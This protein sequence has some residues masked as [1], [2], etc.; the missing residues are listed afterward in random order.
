MNKKYRILFIASGFPPYEFSENIING[1]L[2]LALLK[3]GHSVNVISKIDEGPIYN[4]IWQD[5][6]LPLK[7]STHIVTYPKINKLRRVFEIGK[8]VVTFKYPLEGIRWAE[9]AYRKSLEYI[10]AGQVDVI[11]TRSPSD[12]AHLVG[13]RLKKEYKIRWIANWN[14]PSTG[15][16]PE[17]YKDNL[18]LWKKVSFRKFTQEALSTADVNTFP[19]QLLSEHFK[20]CFHINERKIKIIPHIM[21]PDF[22]S[23]IVD[24]SSAPLHICHS[25]NLS[26][27]RDPENLFMAIKKFILVKKRKIYFEVLGVATPYALSLIKKH[28]LDKFVKF[29]EPLPYY[30]ALKKMTQYDVLMILE[31]KME[32]SIFL[33]SKITDYAQLNK[34]ILSL[35]PSISEVGNVLQRYGG[36]IIANTVS[37]DDIYEKICLLDDLKAENRLNELIKNSELKEYLGINRILNLYDNLFS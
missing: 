23:V 27:E 15:I 30:A 35:S 8:N 2:V 14:D 7:S 13:L 37:L 11:M 9:F 36:G 3:E 33:P 5:P 17:P 6:W 12:I 32:K 16:W 10:K 21:L 24:K 20:Q 4:S 22:Q 26:V 34:P 18:P 25:G 28:G 31:A 1:K 29:N 19:S